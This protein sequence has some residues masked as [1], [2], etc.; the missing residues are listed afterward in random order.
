MTAQPTDLARFYRG[1]RVLLTGHTGFKGA[2]LALWLA[3][4][5]AE[6][7]GFS[8]AVAEPS[9][10]AQAR[11]EELLDHRLGD[12]RDAAAVDAVVRATRPEVVLHLAAQP[13]VRRSLREP[14]ATY[15][16]NV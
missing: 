10:F 13:L 6:V 9:L 12:V 5:G 15:A 7:T 14:V 16:T 1:K 11:V 8:H 3:E 2:W 4:L